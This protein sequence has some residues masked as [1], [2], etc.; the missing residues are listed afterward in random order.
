MPTTP[1]RPG[2][3]TSYTLGGFVPFNDGTAAS[4]VMI[5]DGDRMDLDTVSVRRLT[6]HGPAD[7]S[8][9]GHPATRSALVPGAQNVRIQVGSA[10]LTARALVD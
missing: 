3:N 1:P 7:I 9:D 10:L 2:P 8:V 6:V 5:G 4:T